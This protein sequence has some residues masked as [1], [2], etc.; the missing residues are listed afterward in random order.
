MSAATL[1]LS[2]ERFSTFTRQFLLTEG[3][4]TPRDLTGFEIRAA[5]A[6]KGEIKYEF[7]IG[8]GFIV[9]AP[10]TG[11]FHWVIPAGT[12]SEMD[13]VYDYDLLLINGGVVERLIQGKVKVLRGVTSGD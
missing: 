8:S 1:N 3:E 2:I 11:V 12:T 6:S 10:E 7:E 9:D 13:G 5:F 4:D